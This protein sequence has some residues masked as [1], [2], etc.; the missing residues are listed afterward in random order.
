MHAVME[1]AVNESPPHP[2]LPLQLM[3]LA[4]SRVA[5]AAAA[6]AAA[7]RVCDCCCSAAAAAAAQLRSCN[8]RSLCAAAA[9]GTPSAGDVTDAVDGDDAAAYRR[10]RLAA[11]TAGKLPRAPQSRAVP[12]GCA[13]EA[14]G[15]T[16]LRPSRPVRAWRLARWWGRTPF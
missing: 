9:A 6:A 4:R 7:P 10:A 12:A 15:A 3:L 5:L 11:V 16:R 13:R 2:A 14:A 8:E 1:S